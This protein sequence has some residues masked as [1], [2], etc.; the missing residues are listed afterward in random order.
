MCGNQNCTKNIFTFMIQKIG[1][2]SRTFPYFRFVAEK[3]FGII[4]P[5]YRV[6]PT[7]ADN[8]SISKITVPMGNSGTAANSSDSAINV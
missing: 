1:I 7:Y 3:R 4:F 5:E 2:D 8:V 6:I